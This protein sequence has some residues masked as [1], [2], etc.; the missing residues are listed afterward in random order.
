MRQ[1]KLFTIAAMAFFAVIAVFTLISFSDVA[2][3]K[4][5]PFAIYQGLN[6]TGGV[7]IPA[8]ST[9]GYKMWSNSP[10]F[11]NQ[12][13]A[14][15]FLYLEAKAARHTASATQ[16][17]PLNIALVLDRSGSMMGDKL[18]YCKKAAQFVVDNLDPDDRV[19]VVI[20]E[21]GVKVLVP[22]T[23]AGNKE[24]LKRM[25]A[26][27]NVAG[28]TCM[29]C[30]ML[31]GY[32]EVKRYF[33]QQYVNRVLLLTDGLA[34]T[35]ISDRKSLDSIAN[36]WAA[37]DRITLSTFGVGADFD[38]KMLT[39]LAE[40]GIGNYY[41]IDK[42][43]NIPPIF[44]KEMKGLLE[45]VAQEASVKLELPANVTV[46]KVYGYRFEQKGS[47]LIIPF[48]DIFSEELKS[49]LVE[50]KLK[51][52]QTDPLV[53]K[54]AFTFNDAV[55]KQKN[56]VINSDVTLVPTVDY[57]VIDKNTD[58]YVLQ[59]VTIFK[60]NDMLEEAMDKADKGDFDGAAKVVS[61]N[62]SYL[63]V[64]KA[65][66][67]YSYAALRAQDSLNI[68]YK[69]RLAEAKTMNA[70]DFNMYQKTN[71]SDNYKGRKKKS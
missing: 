54:S 64:Q 26:G 45:V 46:V 65:K 44:S 17:V 41:F 21:S 31:S 5:Q 69:K 6:D 19:S 49:V 62:E 52:P 35:G 18:E 68:N 4:R 9:I 3:V 67:K 32:D 7:E 23:K 36:K 39:E 50:L 71:R 12:P 29:S 28:G 30:G 34:N 61:A 63:N 70:Y 56:T 60:S 14:S 10:F 51:Q 53:F 38:E 11:I 40:Y 57:A 25:I 2:S 20:Y 58:D 24:Q 48:R 27:I 47:T 33:E 43:E 16:R 66:V 55:T 8:G 15:F 13:D 37:N 1:N 59:Q 22:S 42:P